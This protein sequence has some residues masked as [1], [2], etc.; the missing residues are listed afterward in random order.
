M[1]M[2]TSQSAG[3]SMRTNLY[4][5][6]EMLAHAM[7]VM[8]L[9]STGPV[10]TRMPKN[11]TSTI[12]FRRPVPFEAALIHLQEGVTPNT[13]NFRY[14]DVQ[15]VLKQ[16]GQ[17]ASITDVIEDTHEDPVLNDIVM[18]LG[19]NIGRTT[20]ALNWGVL[21]GGL[22]VFYANGTLRTD[23]N[24]PISLAKQRAV[25]RGL[26]AQKAQKITK[27]LSGS[28]NWGTRTVEAAYVA[29]GHTNLESDIRDLPGFVPTADYGSRQTISE[30]EIGTCEDVR[31][32]LSPDL[33]P[34]E[35]A[36][37][38]TSTMVSTSGTNA[39]VYPIVFFGKEAWGKVALR[40][41][42]SVE[43]TIIPVN[44]KTKDDPLGQ[45]GVAGWKSWHEALILNHLWLARLE[46]AATDL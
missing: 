34:F 30:H 33:D 46:V 22:N 4:A 11:K 41:R 13:T 18:M 5:A 6:Q 42:G 8:V 15:G 17:V 3:L 27:V 14:E 43:P 7:P 23:V 1:T 26:K 45:R 37:A 40:D 2:M 16:Y 25:T 19:E 12:K 36:G 9:D 31:Y 28:V 24:T 21:R 44:Q 10:Q 39:D 35:D 32:I 29:V 20:E 38:A